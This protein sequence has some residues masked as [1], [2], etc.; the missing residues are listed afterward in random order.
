MK[1][2]NEEAADDP[3]AETRKQMP[4]SRRKRCR[5]NRSAPQPAATEP[6]THPASAELAAHP[7]AAAVSPKWACKSPIAPEMTAVSYPKSKPP[8]AATEVMSRRNDSPADGGRERATTSFA[9]YGCEILAC[10]LTVSVN[11]YQ[12]HG[13]YK[14]SSF[15]STIDNGSKDKIYI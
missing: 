7:V 8:S 9:A 6:A 11:R 3:T 5:P 15:R 1:T 12:S 13:C 14:V 4:A 2:E 10:C